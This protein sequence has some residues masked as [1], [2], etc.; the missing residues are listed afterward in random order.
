MRSYI[1]KLELYNILK[2]TNEDVYID[3]PLCFPYIFEE[4]SNGF[5]FCNISGIGLIFVKSG[6]LGFLVSYGTQKIKNFCQVKKKIFWGTRIFVQ[7][8][9]IQN[10]TKSQWLERVWYKSQLTT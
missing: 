8:F 7:K 1:L 9:L 3:F 6:P 5:N 4:P 10:V 2:I